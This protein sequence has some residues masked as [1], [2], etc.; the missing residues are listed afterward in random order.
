MWDDA[1]AGRW[2][3]G[4]DVFVL[5]WNA[6]DC[7]A[8]KVMKPNHSFNLPEGSDAEAVQHGKKGC[9]QGLNFKAGRW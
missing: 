4:T 3:D 9:C 6:E 5:N 8:S 1:A 2:R 7:C